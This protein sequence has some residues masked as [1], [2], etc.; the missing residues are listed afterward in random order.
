MRVCDAEF[1]EVVYMCQPEYDGCQE[2]DS[3]I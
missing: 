1:I 2:Y 3:R